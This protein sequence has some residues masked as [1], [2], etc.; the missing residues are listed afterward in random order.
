M[1]IDLAPWR[2][3]VHPRGPITWFYGDV[4]GSQADRADEARLRWRAVHE[5]LAGDGAAEDDLEALEQALADVPGRGGPL[6]CYMAAAGG[7]LVHN[8]QFEGPP[9]VPARRGHGHAADILPLIVHASHDVPYLLVQA[10]RDG[11]ELSL[12]GASRPVLTRQ[13]DGDDLHLSKV[14]GGG[15]SHRRLQQHTEEVWRMN[16]ATLAD[17]ITTMWTQEHPRLLVVAGDVRA[18]EKLRR[19]LPDNLDPVVVEVDR[20]TSPEGASSEAIDDALAQ[21][22]DRRAAAEEK[23]VLDELAVQIDRGDAAVGLDA[24]VTALRSSRARVLLVDEAASFDGI[25]A[26]LAEPPWVALPEDVDAHHGQVREQTAPLIGVLR[27][28][29]LTDAAALVVRAGHLPG[30]AGMAALARWPGP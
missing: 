8:E 7:V 5:E 2:P 15:W 18:R 17:S 13:V 22:F 20:H 19:S 9:L 4:H 25:V 1:L 28:A 12:H 11:G 30:D 21:E 24:C 3:L 27:A 29:A 23:D 6:T 10:S 14:R 16:A 26:N